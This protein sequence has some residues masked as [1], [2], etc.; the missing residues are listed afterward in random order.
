MN[1][2]CS[3]STKS[4]HGHQCSFQLTGNLLVVL[5][6][7]FF[8]GVSKAELDFHQVVTHHLP[9]SNYVV[10]RMPTIPRG[11]AAKAVVMMEQR[12]EDLCGRLARGNESNERTAGDTTNMKMGHAKRKEEFCQVERSNISQLI[13]ENNTYD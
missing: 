6:E 4:W 11:G 8:H 5:R 3:R 12:F 10:V 13:R 1:D 9:V 7:I 2:Q